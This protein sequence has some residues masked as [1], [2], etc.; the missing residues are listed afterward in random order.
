MSGRFGYK[1][2]LQS[3]VKY[4][5]NPLRQKKFMKDMRVLG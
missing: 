5:G 1:D 2:L 3:S 4:S